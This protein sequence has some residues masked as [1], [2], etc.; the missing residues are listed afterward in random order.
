[1]AP[2]ERKRMSSPL[3]EENLAEKSKQFSHLKPLLIIAFSPLSVSWSSGNG[4]KGSLTAL[5]VKYWGKEVQKKWG[6]HSRVWR[7][8]SLGFCNGLEHCVSNYQ[9]GQLNF[10]TGTRLI[11]TAS[12][13]FILGQEISHS[14]IFRSPM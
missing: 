3:C 10:G 11:I 14:L 13:Y 12:K 6:L 9:A 1:M 4:M 5:M 8:W 2:G 7:A